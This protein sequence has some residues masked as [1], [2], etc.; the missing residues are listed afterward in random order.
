MLRGIAR[1]CA[2]LFAGLLGG[3]N[4]AEPKGVSVSLRVKWP[5]TSTLL[6]AIEFAVRACGF[7]ASSYAAPWDCGTYIKPAYLQAA[8]SPNAF[9][10]FVEVW[11]PPNDQGEGCWDGITSRAG[12]HMSSGM[13]LSLQQALASRQYTAK[14]EMLHDLAELSEVP[15]SCVLR[16]MHKAKSTV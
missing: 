8:D 14:V 13:A 1:I 11:Q 4:A 9:W 7:W 6:E 2:L 5:G 12:Q 16:A 10:S 3:V 15:S